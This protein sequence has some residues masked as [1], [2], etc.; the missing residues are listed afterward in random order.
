MYFSFSVD[1]NTDT[2]AGMSVAVFNENGTIYRNC[3]G[4]MDV[5]NSIPVT[6]DTV[7]EWGSVSKL[8]VWISV[9]QLAEQGKIDLDADVNTYLPEG[10]LH[11]RTY[12]TSITMLNLMN[13]NAGFEERVSGVP[14][15]E[16]VRTNIFEPLGMN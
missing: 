13:N 8:L 6:E 7:M 14:Y 15:Y 3:F 11:N 4:Y 1:E 10:F 12:N 5:K 2:T 16:Y 9:M